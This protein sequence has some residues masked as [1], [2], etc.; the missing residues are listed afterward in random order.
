VGHTVTHYSFHNKMYFSFTVAFILFYF[1]LFYFIWGAV[2]REEGGY[3]V[4]G[5]MNGIGVHDVEFTKNP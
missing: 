2:V 4:L 3:K 1:I 5:E